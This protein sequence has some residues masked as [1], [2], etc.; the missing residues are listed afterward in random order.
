MLMDLIKDASILSA[1]LLLFKKAW[2]ISLAP[3]LIL[4]PA[5]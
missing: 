3:S 4:P 5:A 1:S 2:L